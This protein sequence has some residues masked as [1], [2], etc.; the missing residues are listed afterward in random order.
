MTD[1]STEAATS[2]LTGPSGEEALKNAELPGQSENSLRSD[3]ET[4]GKTPRVAKKLKSGLVKS[5]PGQVVGGG[6]TDPVSVAAIYSGA[7]KSL[8]IH[9]LQRRLT[10]LGY[11]DAASAIDGR[12]DALT[13]SAVHAWQADNGH[14][15][16]QLDA[17]QAREL[18]KGDPNVEVAD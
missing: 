10:D 11:N 9:H 16:G 14:D 15:E 3:P 4:E 8:S 12:F 7:K 2:G 17:S 6:D 13:E 1:A 5:E 18:F